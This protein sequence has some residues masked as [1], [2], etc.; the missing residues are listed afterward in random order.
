MRLLLSFTTA[1]F[2]SEVGIVLEQLNLSVAQ[3]VARRPWLTADLDGD[4]IRS[5]QS[6]VEV[7]LQKLE[8]SNAATHQHVI[9]QTNR[10]LERARRESNIELLFPYG[11]Y[12]SRVL[13][14]TQRELGRPV[15]FAVQSDRELIGRTLIYHLREQ[16]C[17]TV[18]RHGRQT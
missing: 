16:N 7:L 14:T 3:Q 4:I 1:S 8:R 15:D 11:A 13:R 17:S 12:Y 2:L 5:E 9:Q 10:L 18:R 6:A